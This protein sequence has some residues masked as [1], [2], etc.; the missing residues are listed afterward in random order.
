M[1]TGV[2]T[3]S[4]NL[5]A[6][7]QSGSTMPAASG[8]TLGIADA[9]LKVVMNSGIPTINTNLNAV[10]QSGST[11][12]A[13]SGVTLGIADA[14]LKV[15]MNSGIPTINTNLNAVMQ[16]GSTI[17]GATGAKID[18]NTSRVT[19]IMTTGVATAANLIATGVRSQVGH[20]DIDVKT[21]KTSGILT[22]II[23]GAGGAKK[24]FDLSLGNTF[25]HTLGADT[26]FYLANVTQGQK[27]I[28]RTQQD[29]TASRSVTWG[30]DTAGN[31]TVRWAE[32]GTAPTGTAK[33]AG[34]ADVYGFIAIATGV[35]DGFV[36]GNNLQ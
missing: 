1:T 14:N 22:P 29:G 25:T 5:N 35:Y 24:T 19:T 18:L 2:A 10:M 36:I 11:M 9:N 16:S 7:M 17:P 3:I 12:P 8:V 6:V 20:Y 32:G 15:V 30:F 21:T 27:F 4:T 34:V 33:P 26:T 31:G 28:I 23:S 13:A